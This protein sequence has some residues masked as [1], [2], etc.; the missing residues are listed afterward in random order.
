[1]TN[2]VIGFP[3]WFG[4]FAV[5]LRALQGVFLALLDQALG[6]TVAHGVQA[7]VEEDLVEHFVDHTT[8]GRQTERQDQETDQSKHT[9]TG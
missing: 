1:M 5:S 6:P 2:L 9:F 3:V 4:P 8:C 7:S